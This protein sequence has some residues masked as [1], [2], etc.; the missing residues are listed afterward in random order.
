MC[1]AR[2]I[3]Y[4]SLC[5]VLRMY[6]YIYVHEELSSTDVPHS[7]RTVVRK[8]IFILGGGVQNVCCTYVPCAQ[9]PLDIVQDLSA[10]MCVSQ[11]ARGD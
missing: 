10:E 6:I 2:G 9:S 3:F 5:A 11:Y 4:L 1:S 7:K 8:V